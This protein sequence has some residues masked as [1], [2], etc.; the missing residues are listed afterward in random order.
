MSHGEAATAAASVAELIAGHD[1]EHVLAMARKNFLCVSAENL[2][3]EDM[4]ENTSETIEKR[5]R[6]KPA[7]K[8]ELP[9]QR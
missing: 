6:R 3:F 7:T 9:A 2:I 5:Q 8:Q 1:P 4:K